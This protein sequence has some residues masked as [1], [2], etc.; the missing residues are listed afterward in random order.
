MRQDGIAP[1]KYIPGLEYNI[2]KIQESENT[3]KGYGAS[4]YHANYFWIF[5]K[6]KMK[7]WSY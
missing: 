6:A 3:R 4:H 5:K 1:Q 2:V 7:K